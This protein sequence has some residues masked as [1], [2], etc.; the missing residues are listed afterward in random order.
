MRNPPLIYGW[1]AAETRRRFLRWV[2]APIPILLALLALMDATVPPSAFYDPA[3]LIL[4]CNTVFVGGVS[5]AICLI[6]LKNYNATGRMQI[7][8]LGCGVLIFGIGGVAAAVVRNLP[9]G[10]NLND[11]VYN[12]GALA[13]ACCHFAAA[14]LVL[15]GMSPEAGAKRLKLW[16]HL[17]YGG[18]I[19]FMAALAAVSLHHL[20]P[21]YFIQGV[22]PTV[23]RQRVLGAADILFVFSF[24]VFMATYIRNRE[25]F[26][27]W[28]ACALALT[29]ISLTAFLMGH[30]VG[31]PVGW[32]GRLSQYLAG[33]YFFAALRTAALSAEERGASLDDVLAA[34]LSGIDERFRALT[35]NAPDAIRRFDRELRHIYANPAALRL[36]GKPAGAVTGKTMKE[37]GIPEAQCKLWNDR[38]LK[39]FETGQSMEV[40]DYVSTAGG[41]VFLQ[42][43]CVPEFGPDGGVAIVLVV[44]RDL[45]GRRRAEEKVSHHNAILEGINRILS[46]ALAAETEEE[47]G[48]K[49]LAVAEQVTGSRFGFIGEIDSERLIPIALS[50]PGWDACRI[51]DSADANKAP[52]A[53]EIRGLHGRVLIDSKGYFTN[54]PAA[55]PDSIGTPP[56]HPE[57]TGFLGVPLKHE[58]KV[59]GMIAMA[60]REGGYRSQDL[61]A[62]EALAVAVVQALMRKRAEQAV[63]EGE[64]RLRQAQKM[65]SIGV[66]AGGIAHD[67]NNLLVGILG[68]ASLL[69]MHEAKTKSEELRVIVECSEK[70]ASLTRQLLAY[71]GKG[72]FEVADFDISRLVRSSAD[73]LRVS[74]PKNVEV[75][76]DVPR[77]LPAVRGDSSQIQQVVMNLVINAAEAIEGRK[78]GRVEIVAGVRAFGA[79]A[80]SR[81]GSGIAAGRYVFIDVRDNGCG[82]DEQTR[83]RI[84]DPFFTT[85]FTGRGLG[86]AAVEG[87]LKFHKGAIA[88]ESTP[89]MGSTFTIY[90]PSIDAPTDAPVA[91]G[92]LNAGERA[93]TVL[94]IDDEGPVRAFTKVALEKLGHTALLAANG[95]EALEMLARHAEIDLALVDIVM[96]VMG[97]VEA[98]AQMRELKPDLAFL[99]AS[100]YSRQEAERMGMPAGSPFIGKPYTVQS[101]AAAIDGVLKARA[102]AAG[103]G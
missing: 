30:S 36:I 95:R 96:P 12:T 7:L 85:K 72:Q 18:S 57:I 58:G 73:L 91:E 33:V 86:L 43:H 71:A 70:A 66:L 68:N 51:V 3:W 99:V 8:L 88:V 32:V 1:I 45:T 9:D 82:I 74:I 55:H 50:D 97:G 98:L 31:S 16:L 63:R 19:L 28:Y 2:F 84:F 15:A 24:L 39:V 29:A 103:R 54:N 48:R 4:L 47:L 5:F 100:G 10:A 60:N 49:C 41:D 77:D 79:S 40:E 20:I 56:G 44:S 90:L 102:S 6:A 14:L 67:F 65:E 61:E 69:Q 25:R 76:L 21:P 37:A 34:C 35:E 27:Y 52:T 93:A 64:E 81:I 26:V 46:E 38:L 92:A 17:G 62:L 89:G 22:G 87:I 80:A 11:T 23:L 83:A 75:L 94:V 78:G 101:L 53:F 13:G 42:S 59:I